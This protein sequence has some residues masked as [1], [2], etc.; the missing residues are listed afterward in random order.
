MN[1]ALTAA[2]AIAAFPF[3]KGTLTGGIL[4]VDDTGFSIGFS[5][6]HAFFVLGGGR[7]WACCPT[8]RFAR[9]MIKFE[10]ARAAKFPRVAA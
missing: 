5:G 6:P 1:L 7:V 4:N 8:I 9:K 2:D 10:V 3:V